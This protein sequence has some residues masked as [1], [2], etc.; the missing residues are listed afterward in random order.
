[1]TK[2]LK[3]RQNWARSSVPFHYTYLKGICSSLG[4][5]TNMTAVMGMQNLQAVR[6][7]GQ[8][9]LDMR[10]RGGWLRY[11]VLLKYQTSMFIFF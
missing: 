4:V 7:N 2:Q 9:S 3:A 10:R 6:Q 1:M 8:V 5:A 11:D